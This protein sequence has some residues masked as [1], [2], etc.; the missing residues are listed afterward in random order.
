MSFIGDHWRCLENRLKILVSI[1]LV[2]IFTQSSPQDIYQCLRII[3]VLRNR[4]SRF[5]LFQKQRLFIELY[6]L[7]L[8]VGTFHKVRDIVAIPFV[9]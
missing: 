3:F 8:N 6:L 7:Y 2:P 9:P 4:L 5:Q 1:D